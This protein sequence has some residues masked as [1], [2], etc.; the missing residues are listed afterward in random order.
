[1]NDDLTPYIDDILNALGD[2]SEKEVTREELEKELKKFIEYGVPLDH[3]KQ[4]LIKKF[5]GSY[6]PPSSERMLVA[7]L[8]SGRNSVHVLCRV[9]H[10]SPKDITVK[11][12]NRKIFYGILGDESGSISFTAWNDFELEKG[13]VVE[14]SNA[15]T[16]EWQ[17]ETK[18]N[19]GDRTKI[20]KTDASKIPESSL[21]PKE[22]KVKDLRSGLGSVEV[23]A[24]I[25]ELNK[26]EVEVDGQKK[27]VFSG[28]LGDE[29]GKA[30]QRFPFYDHTA[31]YSEAATTPDR[32]PL[33]DR[34]R[35]GTLFPY[36]KATATSHTI[37]QGQL[38]RLFP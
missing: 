25:L 3:A 8:E 2:T 36:A 33:R 7:D 21:E 5:G 1:M 24:R 37:L 27:N 26:R 29:T 10:I 15:Y 22:F 14:I 13:D 16:K 11:G 32:F 20:E 17:G 6:M 19:L 23:T 30:P 38:F 31:L 34:R 18:L 35:P 12:E 28:T 9:L 4:T